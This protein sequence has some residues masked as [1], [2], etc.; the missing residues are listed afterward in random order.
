MPELQA[1]AAA[2]W[3]GISV[4]CQGCGYL[5]TIFFGS[6]RLPVTGTLA[7]VAA[8]LRCSRCKVRPRLSDVQAWCYERP[9]SG[10]LPEPIAPT[11]ADP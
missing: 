5:S 3:D 6:Q 4:R 10:P 8:K 11:A 2:G 9:Y 7:E 1:L